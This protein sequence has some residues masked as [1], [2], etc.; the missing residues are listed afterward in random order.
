MPTGDA[1]GRC[2]MPTA[3]AGRRFMA[4]VQAGGNG[5]EVC[6]KPA[7]TSRRRKHS[8]GTHPECKKCNE[9]NSNAKIC[10]CARLRKSSALV[11]EKMEDGDTAMADE[12][13]PDEGQPAHIQ[14]TEVCAHARTHAHAHARVRART[15][16]PACTHAHTC[17]AVLPA[18][19]GGS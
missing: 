17:G 1:D 13:Q 4:S 15:C 18:E 3:S 9:P 2:R 5:F 11:D 6:A 8:A 7:E 12:G 16:T 14:Q 19:P 10:T